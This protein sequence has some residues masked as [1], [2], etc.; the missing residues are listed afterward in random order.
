MSGARE[1]GRTVDN[2]KIDQSQQVYQLTDRVSGYSLP[3]IT[4]FMSL[5]ASI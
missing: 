4:D 3:F 1:V 5:L 2:R